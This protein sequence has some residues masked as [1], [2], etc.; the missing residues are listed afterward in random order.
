MH[1]LLLFHPMITFTDNLASNDNFH[2]YSR[3]WILGSEDFGICIAFPNFCCDL[4]LNF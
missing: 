2:Y 1:F 4:V 3:G